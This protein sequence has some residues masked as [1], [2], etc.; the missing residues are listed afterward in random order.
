MLSPN[1]ARSIAGVCC[2]CVALWFAKLAASRRHDTLSFTA[3]QDAD[4]TSCLTAAAHEYACGVSLCR[5]VTAYPK[6]PARSRPLPHLPAPCPR[7]DSWRHRRPGATWSSHAHLLDSRHCC[8]DQ[9]PGTRT[10]HQPTRTPRAAPPPSP[11]LA[12]LASPRP[13][14]RPRPRLVPHSILQRPFLATNRPVLYMLVSRTR[15]PR[16][17]RLASVSQ[18]VLCVRANH[19]IACPLGVL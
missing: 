13:R 11:C 2:C 8:Q 6:P 1:P 5:S 12:R 10:R 7:E 19:M 17:A 14:P 16:Q 3:D 15:Q 4:G 9:S 18:D